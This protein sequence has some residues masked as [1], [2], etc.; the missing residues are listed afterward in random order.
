MLS[1]K[2][3]LEVWALLNPVWLKETSFTIGGEGARGTSFFGWGETPPG[4]DDAL[5]AFVN[6][7][8]IVFSF[9]MPLNT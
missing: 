7:F 8:S 5:N 2:R 6:A 1:F 9:V 4:S 3:N